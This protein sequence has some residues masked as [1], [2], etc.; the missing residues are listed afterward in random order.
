MSRLGRFPLF[1][2]LLCL[3]GAALGACQALAGIDNRVYPSPQCQDYCTRIMKQCPATEAAPHYEAYT[4]IKTCFGIC[5]LLPAGSADE[6]TPDN[7]LACRLRQL[8]HL[9][10]PNLE[11]T[12]RG[13]Y[14]ARSGPGGSSGP[15]DIEG[16][17]SNCESYC[18][19]YEAA[20]Q[21]DNPPGVTTAQYDPKTCESKCQGLKDT[22]SFDTGVNY[23]GDT[24]QCRL[25]HTSAA[26]VDPKTHCVHAELQPQPMTPCQDTTGPDWPDCDSFC[27]LEMTECTDDQQIYETDPTD[28]P[29]SPSSTAQC[30]AVCKA[31][32]PGSPTDTTGNTVGCRKYHSYNALGD[33][34]MHCQHTGPGSEGLCEDAPASMAD[35][36]CQSYCLLLKQACPSD[37]KD[38]A[39]CET[40]C[41]NLDPP[42]TGYSYSVAKK[43]LPT[44]N[45]VECRLLHV[46]RALSDATE[47]AAATGA[48]PCN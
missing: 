30:V 28:P 20:C 48:T 8:A 10:D 23:T 33:A 38:E 29:G 40:D 47:C 17:G 37:F 27:Q 41:A 18:Q 11:P 16:C 4:D 2:F 1:A 24:L 43:N 22:G 46:S 19:L 44:G 9:D 36:N 6:A 26:T 5:S 15:H 45:N 21:A 42:P 35:G 31:L 3:S 32:P 39:T 34:P 12:D 25:V 14:C 13:P 7:S